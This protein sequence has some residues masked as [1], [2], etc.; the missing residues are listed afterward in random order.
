MAPDRWTK[1]K[2]GSKGLAATAMVLTGL[3]LLLFVCVLMLRG[4]AWVIDKALPWV[5]FVAIC[6]FC[7]SLIVF[8]PLSFFRRT[9]S[10]SAVC[11]LLASYLIGLWTWCYGFE[12]AF[13]I[14]G[15]TGIIV[16]MLLGGVGVF[17]VAVLAAMFRAE[18]WIVFDLFVYLAITFGL[19][20]YS[21]FLNEKVQRRA[22]E[23]ELLLEPGDTFD[24]DSF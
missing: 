8:L 23:E 21:I 2:E 11:F 14:W 24:A 9:R 12:V 13:D 3:F 19:R 5:F 1:V 17:P 7:L 10:V 18:W 16:G 15:T 6:A 20:F 4:A 22:R